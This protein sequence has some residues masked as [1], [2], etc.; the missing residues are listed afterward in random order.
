MRPNLANRTVWQIAAGPV[1]GS[2]ADIFLRYGVALIGPGDAGRWTPTRDDQDFNGSHVRR[3]ASEVRIGD[4]LLLR[5]GLSRIRAIGVVASDYLYLHQFDDVNGLDLQHGRRVRWCELPEEYDFGWPVFGASPAK[6]S[7]VSNEDVVD[8]VRRF[9]HSP[10]NDWQEAPLPLLPVEEP[11][12]EDV[13]E[14]LADLVA[15]AAD[16]SSFVGDRQRFGELPSEDEM[17]SHFVVPFFR[18]LGWPPERIGVKWRYIDV[19]VFERLPRSPENCRFVIE[20]KRLGM[21]AEGALD[22][23]KGYLETLGVSCDVLVTDG[24]R[25]RLYAAGADFNSVGYANLARLKRSAAD[26]F[27]RLRRP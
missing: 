23:A 19:V 4:V 12:L 22:Q 1:S 25:Y 17:I 27:A 15:Q 20:A 16:L 24:I 18:A 14:P 13:P 10:P 21:G 6:L 11:P 5:T 3:F 26:L 9:L 8:F 2:Y 7:R